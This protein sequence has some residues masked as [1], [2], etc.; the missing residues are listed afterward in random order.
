[1]TG[2]DTHYTSAPATG[3]SAVANDAAAGSRRRDRPGWRLDRGAEGD[4]PHAPCTRFLGLDN[5]TEYRVRVRAKNGSSPGPWEFATGTP[6]ATAGAVAPTVPRNVA[7]TPSDGKLT[8][9]W[10]APSSWG[11]WTAAYFDVEWKRSSES[12]FRLV[13]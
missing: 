8:M 11:S 1:M 7:V 2:Y 12:R 3:S 4:P 9:A 13:A 10:Q 6:D 5:G